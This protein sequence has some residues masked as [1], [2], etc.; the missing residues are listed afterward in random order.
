MGM[1]YMP[2]SAERSSKRDFVCVLFRLF[3]LVRFVVVSFASGVPPEA[4]K[5]QP[6]AVKKP[7]AGDKKSRRQT[8][9]TCRTGHGDSPHRARQRDDSLPAKAPRC[10][11]R[12]DRLI[13]HLRRNEA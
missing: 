9:G 10:Y 4:I 12:G 2:P 13:C 7:P 6:E 5:K 11:M 1:S 8:A 3:C